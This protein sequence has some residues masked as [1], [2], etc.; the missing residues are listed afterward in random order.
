M[1]RFIYRTCSGHKNR[2]VFD[3]PVFECI[4][5]PALVKLFNTKSL[6]YILKRF[7]VLN[8]F[9]DKAQDLDEEWR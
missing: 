6:S 3:D 4:T 7:P 8:N 2:I 9:I 5:N 1:S